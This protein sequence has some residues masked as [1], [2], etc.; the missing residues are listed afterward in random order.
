MT[1]KVSDYVTI[2]FFHVN[3]FTQKLSS[4]VIARVNVGGEI[5][6]KTESKSHDS[7]GKIDSKTFRFVALEKKRKEII[8]L[9]AASCFQG[10]RQK[11]ANRGDLDFS[12]R[13]GR[14]TFC[15]RR[16]RVL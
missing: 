12:Y 9:R 5:D 7:N 16:G 2:L 11:W 8:T 13:R 14:S 15:S 10:R 3:L 6:S 4:S 1:K